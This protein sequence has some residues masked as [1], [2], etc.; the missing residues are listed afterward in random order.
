MTQTSVTSTILTQKIRNK[1]LGHAHMQRAMARVR[2]TWT[3]N[4]PNKQSN[5]QTN[6]QAHK[7]QKQ[8][9]KQAS[10]QTNHQKHKTQ[11]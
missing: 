5:K 2:C 9:S 3:K 10:E 8:T 6:N 11:G 7:K 1:K 4:E